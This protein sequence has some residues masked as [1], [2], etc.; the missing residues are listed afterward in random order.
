MG[1][2]TI[3]PQSFVHGI[4]AIAASFLQLLI[5]V[6]AREPSWRLVDGLHPEQRLIPRSCERLRSV[7][8]KL[9]DSLVE[10]CD[11]DTIPELWCC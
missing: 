7:N 10:W 11:E 5:P 1:T 9:E 4:E 3:C 8:G 2:M 6:S